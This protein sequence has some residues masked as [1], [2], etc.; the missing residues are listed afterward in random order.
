MTTSTIPAKITTALERSIRES[1]SIY[2]DVDKDVPISSITFDEDGASIKVGKHEF[3][4][5]EGTY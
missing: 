5:D 4:L 3:F 1:L 2:H